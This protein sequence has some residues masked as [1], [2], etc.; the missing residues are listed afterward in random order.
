MASMAI[1]NTIHGTFT[2]N[3]VLNV[4]LPKNA[5]IPISD[6]SNTMYAIAVRKPAP[7]PVIR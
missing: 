6:A 1:A 5:K 4:S 2:P 7:R 3:S